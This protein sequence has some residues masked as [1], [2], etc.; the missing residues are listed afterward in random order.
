MSD[1]R[2]GTE[3]G[4]AAT[5]ATTARI[6]S[7]SFWH[8]FESHHVDS[9]GILIITLWLTIRVVEFALEF[10]YDMETKL[11]GTEKAA[12]IAAVMTPWGIM[13]AL[14]VKFYM[15]LKGKNGPAAPLPG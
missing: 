13:Q 14:L 1:E 4:V 15:D 10:P 5:A 9:L 11:S 7:R 2:R 3:R 8:W 12:I 6:A